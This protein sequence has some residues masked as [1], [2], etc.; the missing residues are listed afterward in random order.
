MDIVKIHY[1]NERTPVVFDRI[2]ELSDGKFYVY[3]WNSNTGQCTRGK[4]FAG[5]HSAGAIEYV[6][7]IFTTL[8]AAKKTITRYA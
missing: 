7:D 4:W 5:G 1:G 6:G 3:T 8:A 2:A